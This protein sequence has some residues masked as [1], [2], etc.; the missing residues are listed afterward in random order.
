MGYKKLLSLSDDPWSL[1][2]LGAPETV[3]EALAENGFDGIELVRWHEPQPLPDVTV[4]G[5]HMPYWPTWLDFWRGDTKSLLR[6]FGSM[7]S[8]RTYFSAASREDFVQQRRVEL[9]ESAAMGAQYAVFHVSHA[10]LMHC[11][12]HAFTYTDEEIVRAFI[13]FI[14]EAAEGLETGPAL[15]FENHWF[16]GLKLTERRLAELLMTEVRYPN[17]GFVLDTSHMML[18]AG[19]KT[20]PEAVDTILGYIDGLGDMAAHIRTVHLNSAAG[21]QPLD[22]VYHPEADFETRL[23]E[24]FSFVGSMDPHRPFQY[25]GIRRVLDAVQPDFLVY[26]LSF[27]NRDELR[28]AVGRQD[29]SVGAIR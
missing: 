21:A 10:E 14:N 18:S 28:E 26:E 6:Q 24:A 13:E 12:N 4:V 27:G 15:L 3:S 25:D 17:K 1:K 16:P 20:E 22:G 7:D 8:V 29:A 5:R 9:L 23:T 19:V 2:K 11:Y